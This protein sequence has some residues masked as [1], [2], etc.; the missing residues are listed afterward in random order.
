MRGIISGYSVGYNTILPKHFEDI[1]K[2]MTVKKFKDQF[3]QIM[4]NRSELT[5]IMKPDQ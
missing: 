3:S 4:A 1:L 2:G 5:V